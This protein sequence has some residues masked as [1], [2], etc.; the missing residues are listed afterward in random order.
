VVTDTLTGKAMTYF[1]PSGHLGSS[2]D[3][4]AFS[5]D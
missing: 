5:G 1:N 4:Q 2:L 3:P